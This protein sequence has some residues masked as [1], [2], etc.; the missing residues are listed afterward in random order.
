MVLQH[1]LECV[2]VNIGARPSHVQHYRQQQGVH[3]CTCK[4]LD[5]SQH[6]CLRGTRRSTRHNC[7]FFCENRSWKKNLAGCVFLNTKPATQTDSFQTRGFHP[8]PWSNC[9]RGEHFAWSRNR[10][11]S[12][13]V[14]CQWQVS[15]LRCRTRCTAVFNGNACGVVLSN[16]FTGR[17]TWASFDRPFPWAI[18]C[19]EEHTLLSCDWTCKKDADF[20]C[21][22]GVKRHSRQKGHWNTTTLVKTNESKNWFPLSSNILWSFVCTLQ[23]LHASNT[24]TQGLKPHKTTSSLFHSLPEQPCDESSRNQLEFDQVDT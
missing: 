12:T 4:F 23:I 15:C 16:V 14:D 19:C 11:C 24:R 20:V 8:V 6:L 10:H 1:A 5:S 7:P 22:Y 3:N 18:P 9:P 13:C 2:H 17:R 21:E